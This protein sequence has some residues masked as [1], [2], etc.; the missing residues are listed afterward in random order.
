MLS[1]RKQESKHTVWSHAEASEYT[2]KGKLTELVVQKT[3]LML[4][5]LINPMGQSAKTKCGI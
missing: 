1:A 2:L 4:D 3:K 5:I